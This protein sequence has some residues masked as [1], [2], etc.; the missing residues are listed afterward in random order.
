M[1]SLNLLYLT[2]NVE[3]YCLGQSLKFV[4]N[5]RLPLP[6]SFCFFAIDRVVVFMKSGASFSIDKILYLA[7]STTKLLEFCPFLRI[8]NVSIFTLFLSDDGND[9]Q[10]LPSCAS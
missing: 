1:L 8:K 3:S 5:K 9:N 7:F 4:S 10:T 6:S 2:L